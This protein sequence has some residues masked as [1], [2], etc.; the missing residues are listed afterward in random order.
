[1]IFSIELRL[2]V[3]APDPLGVFWLLV[4]WSE[5]AISQHILTEPRLYRDAPLINARLPNNHPSLFEFF[6]LGCRTGS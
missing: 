2:I 1:M 5:L 3:S 6:L 4:V